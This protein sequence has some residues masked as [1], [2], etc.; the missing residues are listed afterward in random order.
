[1][2]RDKV[3]I[4]CGG[5]GHRMKHVTARIPKPLVRLNGKPVL[6]HV[7]E[8]YIKK[9]FHDFVLCVG[10]RSDDIYKFVRSRKFDARIDI[11]NAGV[12]ASMLKRICAVR[13]L[14]DER[15]IVAYGDTFIDIDIHRML[16]EHKRYPAK[17]T[18]TIADIRSPFGLVMFDN[19]G[20]V[21]L[22]EEKPLLQYYVGHM[23]V[24][25]SALDAV[26]SGMTSM[27]D[28]EGLIRFFHSLI[29]RKTLYCF[30]H[31]G[32]RIT[33]NTIYEHRK[34]EETF[35]RFFTEEEGRDEK[36]KR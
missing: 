32:L 29:K 9:N 4:L 17:A 30:R 5:R 28:G 2:G 3:I 15:A 23:I 10:Y 19:A 14:L 18:I 31:K 36:S 26:S 16:K 35:T 13:H 33:F 11:S 20:R 1:M 12:R 22:F 24:E 34:A 6:E 21:K 7:I 27:P 25:R 8:F